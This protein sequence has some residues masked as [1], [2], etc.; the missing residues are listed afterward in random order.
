MARA[1]IEH[2]SQRFLELPVWLSAGALTVVATAFTGAVGSLV[3]LMIVGELV[4]TAFVLAFLVPAVVVPPAAAIQIWAL[5]RAYIS[6]REARGF[7]KSAAALLGIADWNGH[8]IR[9]SPSWERLLGHTAEEIGAVHFGEFVH[10]DDRDRTM[11][12][13]KKLGAGADSVGF[14]NR[15]RRRDGTYCWLQWTATSDPRRQRIYATAVDISERMEA[16][17]IRDGIVSTVNHEIRTPLASVSGALKILTDMDGDQDSRQRMIKIASANTER[18]VR[19]VD[20]MLDL[21]RDGAG[22]A[23]YAL[24]ACAVGTLLS[25]AVADCRH[26]FS[27]NDTTLDVRELDA[28]VIADSRRFH[29]VL[30]NLLGNAAKFAPAGSTVRLA[31]TRHDGRVRFTVEDNGPGIA[32]K[33]RDQIFNRFYQGAGGDHTGSG[34]GLSICRAF[35]NGM[36]GTIEVDTSAPR[37][38]RFHVDLPEQQ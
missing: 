22:V 8:F 11:E 15:L 29:Q 25:D 37:G 20:D 17:A 35:V 13:A 31:A 28:S 33:D 19:M 32:V 26:L 23:Q 1:T 7:F 14:V 9:V 12:E 24:E 10:P 5:R 18:F 21:E 34:L 3:I 36:N 38:A 27:R 4:P 30:C 16:E 6:E 2:I